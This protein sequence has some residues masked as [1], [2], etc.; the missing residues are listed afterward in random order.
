MSTRAVSLVWGC[1]LISTV[2]WD[3]GCVGTKGASYQG[4]LVGLG[5]LEADDLQGQGLLY[6]GHVGLPRCLEQ[7]VT[8]ELVYKSR[9][10]QREMYNCKWASNILP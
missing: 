10:R 1:F 2:R 6:L 3:K 8:F 7:R 9:K 4:R 5:V